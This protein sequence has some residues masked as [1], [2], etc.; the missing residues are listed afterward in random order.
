MLPLHI[1]SGLSEAPEFGLILAKKGKDWYEVK[2]AVPYD[3][4][5]KDRLTASSLYGKAW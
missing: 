3:D 2:T 4:D 1:N 5:V